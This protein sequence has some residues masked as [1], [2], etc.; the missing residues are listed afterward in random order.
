M[1]E[2]F[3]VHWY[4]NEYPNVHDTVTVRVVAAD[5]MG[6][7][8][9]L[10]EYGSKEGMI[11]PG[12]YTTVRTRRNPN[13]KV[14]KREVALVGSVDAQ[15]ENMDLTRQGLKDDDVEMA[16]KKFNDQK[17]VMSMLNWLSQKF[18][19][20]LDELARK[21]SDPLH[22]KYGSA[23]SALCS[24]FKDK[25][26]L[27]SVDIPAEVKEALLLRVKRVT[28][29]QTIRMR[30]TFEATVLTVGGVEDLKKALKAGYE[31]VPEGLQLSLTVV[32]PPVYSAMLSVSSEVIGCEV[33]TAALSRIEKRIG[34]VKG[35]FQV[36]EQ[37]KVLNKSE[38]E[39]LGQEGDGDDE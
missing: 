26:I 28:T 16:S 10:L 18:K 4:P 6:V 20:S 2:I 8:V 34:E 1:S 22:I 11:P 12:Q 15:K 3:G 39:N 38:L 14:G 13:I 5:E 36:K 32:S 29:P 27:E 35:R 37:P 21:V 7:W 31:D 30:A 23:Y 25:S 33:L 24:S 9:K 17:N 19:I